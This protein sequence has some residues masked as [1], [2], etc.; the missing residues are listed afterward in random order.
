MIINQ[1]N[2][3]QN[4]QSAA[5]A[6][7]SAVATPAVATATPANTAAVDQVF[8]DM[9]G[10]TSKTSDSVA[11]KAGGW[12]GYVNSADKLHGS[13]AVSAVVADNAVSTLA[14]TFKKEKPVPASERPKSVPGLG[15]P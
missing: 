10:I 12:A 2:A 5:P 11:N 8:A 9:G 4:T 7:S 1:L 15:T 3:Q 6:V 13:D 14:S